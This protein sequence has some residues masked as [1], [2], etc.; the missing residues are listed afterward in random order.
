MNNPIP[1]V[2]TGLSLLLT[3]WQATPSARSDEA[4]YVHQG[5]ARQVRQSGKTWKQGDG[6]I[7]CTGTGNFLYAA[8]A[9]GGGD[10]KIEA[11]LA[12]MVIKDTAASFVIGRNNHFGFD[13]EP[14]AMFVEGPMFGGLHFLPLRRSDYIISGK[15]FNFEVNRQG[16]RLTFSIDGKEVYAA[17]VSGFGYGEFGLRPWRSTMR[18]YEFSAS[19]SLRTP[20]VSRVSKSF[21]IPMIDLA[22]ETGR[23]VIVDRVPGQYLGHPTTVLMA[24]GRTMFVTYPLGH[25][26]PAAVLKKSTDG[27]L[28][29]SGRLPVPDNWKTAN[30]CPCL[31]RLTGPDG[32]ERLFVIEG[33]GAFR[34][35]VSLDNGD[36]WTPFKPNGLHGVVAPNTIVS[37]AGNRHLALFVRGYQDIDQPP[38]TIWQS[39]SPDGGLTWEPQTKIVDVVGT[40]FE[41][42][43]PDEPGVIRSPDGKQICALLRENAGQFNSLM[44]L[45]DD[46]GK[47]WSKPVE[48]PAA[49][50]GHR[51]MPRYAQDGRLVVTFRDMAD[52]SPTKGDFAAWVGRYDDIVHGREGQYRIRLLHNRGS[53]GDTG[54]AGLELLPDNTF[55]ATTYCTLNEGEKPCVVCA[56]FKLDEIDARY[57]Q[58]RQAT[59]RSAQNH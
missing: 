36:T 33:N 2:S 30:N 19:G 52:G 51:H 46:E 6:F 40:E 43:C 56:R 25:G 7:E 45:S 13:G 10:A 47:T 26:G 14:D 5:Q 29:W 34:Q 54:Y 39:I 1:R 28:T 17:N 59:P 32:I 44:V 21:T 20:A 55:V 42:A 50:T 35:A 58:M 53:F 12:I 24:D 23:Q 3:L 41:G 11:R 38:L 9:L 49:L 22:N 4:V 15:P 48:L 57:Q 18:V 16:Q 27:G 37:I 31:H 8:S